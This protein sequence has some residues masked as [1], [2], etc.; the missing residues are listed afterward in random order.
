M[1]TAPEHQAV[2]PSP[3]VPL[4]V[5]LGVVVAAGTWYGLTTERWQKSEELE[6]AVSRL[7]ELPEHIGDWQARPV[8]MD[9]RALRQAGA[10]GHWVRRFTHSRTGASVTII[11]LCGRTGQMAVH[12]P[13]DCYR[14]AGYEI[15]SPAT[16]YA[17]RSEKGDAES[18]FWTA[19][20]RKQDA[21]GP[22]QLRIF[23]SWLASDAWQAPDSPR[24]AFAGLPVLY[25][26]YAVHELVGPI[27]DDPA[28]D[29]LHRLVPPLTELLA[30]RQP[31][32]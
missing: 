11:L 6:A 16:P 15:S 18:R 29:L 24:L 31:P 3:V 5:A 23:W 25:K 27:E 12:R 22:V 8:E 26:L 4:V 9:A 28:I 14:G 19:C 17:S 32:G 1:P 10:E 21:S 2:R 20:F 7:R 13:E 30:I